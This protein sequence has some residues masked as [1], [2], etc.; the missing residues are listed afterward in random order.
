MAGRFI[1]DRDLEEKAARAA[2]PGQERIADRI[3]DAARGYAP[4]ERTWRTQG[5]ERVRHEHR[6]ADGQAIPGN[7]RFIVRTPLYDR[8][9]YDPHEFQQLRFPRDT[10]GGTPGNTYECVPSWVRIDATAVQIGYRAW[11]EGPLVTVRMASGRVLTGTANHPVLTNRGW[12]GLSAVNVGHRLVRAPIREMVTYP[13]TT[14][15]PDVEHLPPTAGEVFRAL[16]QLGDVHRVSGLSVNFHGDR[17]VGEVDVVTAD[18]ELRL[19]L[20]PALGEEI[21]QVALPHVLPTAT[22]A[23]LSLSGPLLG[24][25]GS[26]AHGSVG[27]GGE[28][29]TLV[30]GR[31]RH[32]DVH[33]GRSVARFDPDLQEPPPDSPPVDL[34]PLGQGL[35]ALPRQVST[36]EVIEVDVHPWSGHVYT[37]QT[38]VGWYAA[39]GIVSRNCRCYVT[40]DPVGVAKTITR[41]RSVVAGPRVHVTVT[42]DHPR[43]ADSEF[44]TD[45]DTP[46]RFMGRAVLEA[47]H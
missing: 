21:R 34:V 31:S 12:V 13:A 39:A 5:D 22:V 45:K 29:T 7:L 9:H 27:G 37:F 14:G 41:S 35:L 26:A 18:R 28:G 4:E 42:C 33:S 43:A 17:P 3:V 1:P 47:G 2:A 16:T 11:Y 10:E 8:E 20:D 15:G 6:E 19:G 44:G 24:G 38:D 30:R 40:T 25:V 36:D 32:T 46:A 23:G